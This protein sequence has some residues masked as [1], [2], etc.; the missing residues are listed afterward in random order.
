MPPSPDAQA[1]FDL[2]AQLFKDLTPE[3]FPRAIALT[4]AAAASG[5]ADAICQL[6][7]IE[8]IGAG[9]PRSFEKAMQ[10][11]VQA[12][13]LGSM[14]AA[15]QLQLLGWPGGRD[16]QSLFATPPKEA[17]SDSPRILAIRGFTPP[18]VCDWI[19]QRSGEKL[20]PAMIWDEQSGT[21]RRDPV[22]TNSSLELRLTDMDVVL[23]VERARISAA[24]RLPEMIFETPQ[25]MRYTVGQEFKLHHDYLDPRVPGHAIDIERRGQRIG[26]F[27]VYLNDEFGGGETDFPEAGVSFRGE[28]GDALFFTNVGRDGAPDVRS[29][30]AGRPPSSGEKW[31]LSQWIRDRAPG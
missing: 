15:K 3:S 12:S 26:T 22:R 2:A 23:A 5:H 14:H 16:V 6:A 19:I 7:T 11:L 20:G 18:P 31:I 17:L 28:K 25:V 13:E 4:E 24:T 27:L 29:M 1:Q 21:G 9:R 30:H 10:L 8:A